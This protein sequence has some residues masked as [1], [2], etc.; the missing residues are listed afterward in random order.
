MLDKQRITEVLNSKFKRIYDDD[1]NPHLDKLEKNLNIISDIKT[2]K[3]DYPYLGKVISRIYNY[4]IDFTVYSVDKIISPIARKNGNY[5]FFVSARYLSRK[6]RGSSSTWNRNLNIFITLGLVKKHPVHDFT[7]TKSIRD[8]DINNSRI[9]RKAH[10]LKRAHAGQLRIDPSRFKVINFYSIPAYDE[11]CLRNA[12]DIAKKLVDNNFRMN[13]FS[14]IFLIKVF[15][16]EF[17]N[18]IFDDDRRVTE[19][20]DYIKT[21]IETFI[22]KDMKKYGYTYKQRIIDKLKINLSKVKPQEYGFNRGS[23]KEIISREFDRSISE[24]IKANNLVYKKANKEL[25]ERFKLKGYKYI[26]YKID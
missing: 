6:F 18:Q 2:L 24:I 11:N 7:G 23:R 1:I 25:K 8:N 15:G 4:L 14:K 12:N 5:Y 26:I 21:K 17:A 10:R 20:S 19:Y 3:N 22:M 16:E 13:A 9:A